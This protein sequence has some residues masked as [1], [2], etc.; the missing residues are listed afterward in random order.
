MNFSR[1]IVYTVHMYARYYTV[2]KQPVTL[3]TKVAEGNL[4]ITKPD[5]DCDCIL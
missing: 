1:I 2:I 4:K 3:R 5:I